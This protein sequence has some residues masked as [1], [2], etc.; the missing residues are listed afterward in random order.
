MRIDS[1]PKLD[2]HNVLI[3]PKR[4][5]L[6]SRSE[7]CLSRNFT[8][9][10]STYSW[11]GIPIMA[12]NMDTTGTFEMAKQLYKSG[13]LTA[14]T[15]HYTVEDFYNVVEEFKT[16]DKNND[17]NSIWDNV[18]VSTGIKNSDLEKTS[19][20]LTAFPDI[21]WVCIDVANGYMEC[22]VEACKKARNMWPNHII[23]AGNVV[24]REMVEELIINGGVDIC[25]VGIG[26]GSACI[27]RMKT[28]VGMPQLSAVIE[29]SDA[30]HGVGGY[31]ISDG[32]ITCP[33]DMAK[34][35][36]GG[37]DFTMCGG[38]FAGHDE[39][40]GEIIEENGEKYKLFYGMS[41]EHAMKKHYG[42]MN[43]Y[44][45]SEGRVLKVKYKGSVERTV[46]D[47]LGGIRSCC[48]YIGAN[49][50]RNMPKCTTFVLVTQQLNT[51]LL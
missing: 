5:T 39:T 37:A 49:N 9:P 18:I 22:F 8:F 28:G 35:F 48:T 24:S 21:K 11:K 15:K 3:R 16:L 51:S 1:V 44:R 40:P 33:G 6:S 26:G 12:A 38:V 45:S 47:Y 13:M 10:H 41:S 31:I 19:K 42:K 4:S 7:V 14:L 50:I 27:T 23:I 36:G 34:A 43:N 29:C 25:K 20:I 2:F 30:A 17:G 32:G 46:Q